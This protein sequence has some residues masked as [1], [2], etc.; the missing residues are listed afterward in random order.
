MP[1][2]K[3]G[4]GATLQPEVFTAGQE[5]LK[6]SEGRAWPVPQKLMS[7]AAA[8]QT[9]LNNLSLRPASPTQPDPTHR[10]KPQRRLDPAQDLFS[11]F[12]HFDTH[13]Q[14][15][16]VHLQKAHPA[17][18]SSVWATPNKALSSL[19]AAVQSKARQSKPLTTAHQPPTSRHTTSLVDD[20]HQSL[21]FPVSKQHI[22]S[23][24]TM[25]ETPTFKLVLVGDGG[26][27]KVCPS[28]L[29]SSP[30]TAIAISH[31]VPNAPSRG[32]ACAIFTT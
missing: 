21:F 23:I 11:F 32:A 7:P 19:L 5:V 10:P 30:A 15:F 4:L 12:S 27:G 9:T 3:A 2:G 25:A 17:P 13:L 18:P 29:S 24:T 16:V 1:E 6:G 31:A 28:L 8:S 22:Q 14:R 26:T 20:L